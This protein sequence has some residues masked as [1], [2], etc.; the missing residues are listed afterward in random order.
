MSLGCGVAKFT[1][2]DSTGVLFACVL[3]TEPIDWPR[4]RFGPAVPAAVISLAYWQ[5]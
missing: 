3:E 5:S 4:V 2:D 1:L